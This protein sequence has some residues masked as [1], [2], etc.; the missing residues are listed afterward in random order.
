MSQYY[1]TAHVCA[2]ADRMGI[3]GNCRHGVS[4][5]SDEEIAALVSGSTIITLSELGQE[6]KRSYHHSRYND[7]DDADK[8]THFLYFKFCV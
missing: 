5:T 8:N 7:T 2:L 4:D 1:A 3:V 6:W